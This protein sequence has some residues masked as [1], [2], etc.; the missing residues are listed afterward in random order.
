MSRLTQIILATDAAQRDQS[1]DAACANLS[2]DEL[3]AEC[4]ALDAF[5]RS[6]QN[7]YERV[8][9]L[10]FLAA[11]H[12]FHLPA[13][14]AAAASSSQRTASGLVPFHGYEHLLHRR[15]EEAID[16]FLLIQEREGPSDAISS[17]L[18]AAYHRLAFQIDGQVVEKEL[19][20]GDG[21]MHV[22]ERRPEW[23]CLKSTRRSR[24]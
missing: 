7:L 4:A 16:D 13:K 10:F 5:R 9:A 19:A 11:I 20:C 6:S 23:D 2:T 18:A 24:A 14:L 15:F 17:A 12:R 8:R 21:F 3:L 1:L 22:S